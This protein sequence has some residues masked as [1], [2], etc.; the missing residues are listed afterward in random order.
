[1][2]WLILEK[3]II[4]SLYCL[5]GH[6]KLINCQ[7][8]AG[9]LVGVMGERHIRLRISTLSLFIPVIHM[10]LSNVDIFLYSLY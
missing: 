9:E 8:V 4:S 2:E 5:N 7:S 6:F 10:N 1:M 3:L